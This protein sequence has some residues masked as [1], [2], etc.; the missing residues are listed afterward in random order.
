MHSK[1]LLH[2]NIKVVRY[3]KKE[4]KRWILVLFFGTFLGNQFFHFIQS[5]PISPRSMRSFNSFLLRGG[6]NLTLKKP[7][8]ISVL[9]STRGGSPFLDKSKRLVMGL[10]STVLQLKQMIQQKFPGNPPSQT[11]KIYLGLQLLLNN[12][13]LSEL[14]PAPTI[15]LLLDMF[16]GTTSYNRT[17]SVQQ[18][19]EAWASVQVQQAFVARQLHNAF[20]LL[21]SASTSTAHSAPCEALT[22]SG[23]EM[24]TCAFRDMF[25]FLNETFASSVCAEVEAARDR[26][27]SAEV[28]ALDTEAWRVLQDTTSPLPARGSSQ[29]G[30]E[31]GRGRSKT[32][33]AAAVARVVDIN[34]RRASQLAY[35]SLLL[36]VTFVSS[37]SC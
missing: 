10:N 5:H 22:G 21:A 4:M 14:S 30:K 7:D 35:L 1:F 6:N 25:L 23:E 8:N 2:N 11:Q 28:A 15:S 27:R 20:A 9:V 12:Q 33:L 18:C 32:P 37:F 19:V 17:M 31:R 13:T 16:C 3:T 36:T 29:W 26:E 24:E 34:P